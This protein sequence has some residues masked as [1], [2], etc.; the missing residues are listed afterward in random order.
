MVMWLPARAREAVFSAAEDAVATPVLFLDRD[1]VVIQERHYLHDPE[2]VTLIP[3]SAEAM[4][5]AQEEGFRL[6]GLSNQSGIGRGRYTEADFAAVQTRVD[7][8]LA[9]AGTGFDAFFYCPH[10][11]HEGCACRKPSPGL[12]REAAKV[13]RW[14]PDHVWLVG[15]KLS[16]VDLALGVGLPA[17]LVRTGYGKEQVDLLGDR[18]SVVVV[19]D[20]AAAV[21][22]LLRGGTA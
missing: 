7:A 4:K 8:M 14:L 9:A 2:L 5:M 17:F 19:D 21:S 22:C 10:A 12:L 16:D 13:V 3:G 11:P 18:T 6:V 1:G 15:D 20:L